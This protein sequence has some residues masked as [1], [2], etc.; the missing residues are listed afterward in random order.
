MYFLFIN[1]KNHI[2]TGEW[3]AIYLFFWIFKAQVCTRVSVNIA[4]QLHF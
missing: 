4:I 2:T 1:K 3:H